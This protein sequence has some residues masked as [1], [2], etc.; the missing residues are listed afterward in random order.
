M[1]SKKDLLCIKY[2]QIVLQSGYVYIW[3]N[4]VYESENIQNRC[5][6]RVREL[7]FVNIK[8]IISSIQ[9]AA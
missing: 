6:E 4:I 8:T 7:V 1:W 3:K 5:D 2:V 9:N